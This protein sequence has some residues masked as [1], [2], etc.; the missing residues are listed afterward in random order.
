MNSIYSVIS[1]RAFPW[2]VKNAPLVAGGV[3]AAG[4]LAGIAYSFF[5][6][7]TPAAPQPIEEE[8]N[9]GKRCDL[10]VVGVGP[11]GIVLACLIKALCPHLQVEAFDK[12]TTAT[13]EHALR[14]RSDS[15]GE[16]VK[17]LQDALKDETF[18]T[19]ATI[20]NKLE[21][22]M[23]F[24][25]RLAM[26]RA[27]PTLEIE[28]NLESYATEDLGIKI[29]RGKNHGVWNTAAAR[30]AYADQVRKEEPIGSDGY[31]FDEFLDEVKPTLVLGTDGAHSEIR[32][33]LNATKIDQANLGRLL[34]LKYTAPHDIRSRKLLDKSYQAIISE[35]WDFETFSKPKPGAL[36]SDRI[37]VTLHK[38]IDENVH[39]A[40]L[41]PQQDPQQPGDEIIRG[42]SK[43]PWSFK[44]L[45]NEKNPHCQ[46]ISN[47]LQMYFSNHHLDPKNPDHISKDRITTIPIAVYQSSSSAE[48][49]KNKAFVLLGGDSS[50]GM[51]FE[52]GFNKGLREAAACARAVKQYFE[53][54][55]P[56]AKH[57]FSKLPPEFQKYQEEVVAIYKN[58]KRWAQAK[59]FALNVSNFCL[60]CITRPFKWIFNS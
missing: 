7:P 5:H 41:I 8:S 36:P 35:G 60:K 3:A 53:H 11:I 1:E 26:R 31:L 37:R 9:L 14:I 43:Y 52:S 50:S 28:K 10:A 56:R 13:R 38:F 49:Y 20:R 34:E 47:H 25:Q 22:L 12:R 57:D 48:A 18:V 55:P 4:I 51:G 42:S 59:Q 58:E 33:A 6:K 27:I 24:F 45:K 21:D 39:Q 19:S 32:Q 44:D 15:I 16:I 2:V 40:L 30:T 17:L 54:V 29:H 46:M 23:R